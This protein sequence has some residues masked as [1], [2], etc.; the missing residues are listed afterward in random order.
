MKYIPLIRDALA[1]FF[2]LAMACGAEGITVIS[3]A[4]REPE[5]V[6]LQNFLMIKPLALQK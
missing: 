4:A 5:I 2:C 6:D 1:L 3:N